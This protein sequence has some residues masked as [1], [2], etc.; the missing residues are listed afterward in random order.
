MAAKKR[1][2]KTK[3]FWSPAAVIGRVVW[4]RGGFGGA[5]RRVRRESFGPRTVASIRVDPVTEKLKTKGLKRGTGGVWEYKPPR[6]RTA[7]PSGSV[8]AR[9]RSSTNVQ[10]TRAQAAPA[11]PDTRADRVVRGAD[12][13]FNGSRPARRPSQTRVTCPWC[14]GTGHR[15]LFTGDGQMKTITGV[16][17]C[18]HRP[19][20]ARGQPPQTPAAEGDYLFCLRCEDTGQAP[21]GSECPTCRGW[22]NRYAATF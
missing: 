15:V 13:R 6:S 11:A 9:P 8:R 14:R 20:P 17:P 10:Q 12:G 5:V 16:M 19:V 2:S 1:K 3:S 18:N 21:D 4:G 22:V 7:K